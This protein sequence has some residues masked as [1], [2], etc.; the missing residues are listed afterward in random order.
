M[1]P[2]SLSLVLELLKKTSFLYPVLLE[3][4]AAHGI[5]LG[6]MF[7]APVKKML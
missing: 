1:P 4:A 2:R 6:G 3:K 7:P 5:D